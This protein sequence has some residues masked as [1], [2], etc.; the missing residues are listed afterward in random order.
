MS[1]QCVNGVDV[2]TLYRDVLDI[3]P[4]L[5]FHFLPTIPRS[6]PLEF[7]R[8]FGPSF[9]FC[10]SSRMVSLPYMQLTSNEFIDQSHVVDRPPIPTD[11]SRSWWI[12]PHLLLQHSM[13]DTVRGKGECLH[14]LRN[15][16]FLGRRRK[17]R[18]GREWVWGGSCQQYV[19]TSGQGTR[20]AKQQ[21]LLCFRAIHWVIDL[22]LVINIIIVE[23]C[24]KLVWDNKTRHRTGIGSFSV[25]LS[26]DCMAEGRG[27]LK[28]NITEMIFS[29]ISPI[30]VSSVTILSR[31]VS[32]FLH[33]EFCAEINWKLFLA[34]SRPWEATSQVMDWEEGKSWVERRGIVACFLTA[35]FTG[36]HADWGFLHLRETDWK[37]SL[38][39]PYYGFPCTL[40]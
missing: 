34:G 39:L 26:R 15:W 19:A 24:C 23:S 8:Y 10:P 38:H 32:K 22:I 6:I 13:S 3:S 2:G 16:C 33:S 12:F 28:G 25:N 36:F 21:G 5:R 7:H 37:S 11:H 14:L 9:L 35:S 27:N 40:S 30:F 20:V 31:N 18:N 1:I 29:R 17:K 4:I